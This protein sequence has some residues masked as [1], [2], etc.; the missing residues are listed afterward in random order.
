MEMQENNPPPPY[1]T[2]PQPTASNKRLKWCIAG[3]VYL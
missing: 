2:P 1:T 3:D